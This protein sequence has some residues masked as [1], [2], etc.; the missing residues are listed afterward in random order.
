MIWIGADP[1][2]I[3]KFGAALLFQDGT[4]SCKDV[5]SVSE[6][7]DFV[8]EKLDVFG[9]GTLA[10]PGGVGIDAP[11]WW[12]TKEGG[13]RTADEWIRKHHRVGQSVSSINSL[14]GAALVQGVVLALELRRRFAKIPVTE[15]HPKALLRALY[16][17]GSGKE[18]QFFK[19][20]P[21]IIDPVNKL[22][23]HQR[24]ALI[25]AVCARE[26]FELRWK[27]NL[28]HLRG[29][30]GEVS[31]GIE[32]VHYGWPHIPTTTSKSARATGPSKKAKGKLLKAK[33]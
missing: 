4:Y 10:L 27:R 8:E 28:A 6:F 9:D 22:S 18:D 3:G 32:D 16:G 13:S 14:Q 20:F 17:D 5:S 21:V 11:L 12:S 30:T 31:A 23:E 26:T 15:S 33:A 29:V 19:D 1:G 24:D 2:G 25:G 7:I